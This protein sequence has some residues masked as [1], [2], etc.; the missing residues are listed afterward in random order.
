MSQ[1]LFRQLVEKIPSVRRRF[2]RKQGDIAM[3]INNLLK[4][5]GWTQR[6]LADEMGK[7][8]SH[9]SR[10]LSGGGNPTIK[11]IVE[12]EEALDAE[13]LVAPMFFEDQHAG[14]VDLTDI[15]VQMALDSWAPWVR[16]VDNANEPEEG[17]IVANVTFT[18]KTGHV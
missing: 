11:T 18:L 7:K 8:E 13:I 12:F 1:S 2:V 16:E 4:E 15:H 9:I 10:I 6:R 5:K 17:A 3:Q 14:E